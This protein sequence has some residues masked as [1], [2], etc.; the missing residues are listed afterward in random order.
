MNFQ[1]VINEIESA[2]NQRSKKFNDNSEFGIVD[3]LIIKTQESRNS[4]KP[5]FIKKQNTV[6]V[7]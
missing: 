3:N 2:I 6:L 4:I 5:P 1:K 7:N